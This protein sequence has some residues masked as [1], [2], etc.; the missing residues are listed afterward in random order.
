[1]KYVVID[2]ETGG[3]DATQH[4]L[5]SVGMIK[6]TASF[7]ELDSLY[8]RIRHATLN[9]TPGSLEHNG[10]D[11]TTA[12][13]WTPPD[14]ARKQILEFLDAPAD[15]ATSNTYKPTYVGT[16]T[17][18][19]F[20]MSFLKVFLGE[21]TFDNLFFTRVEEITSSFR[22]LQ[23][24][25]VIT[26]PNGYKLWH[27]MEAL[28]IEIDP[29]KAYTAVEN[30]GFALQAAREMHMRKKILQDSLVSYV[31]KHGGDLYK[32]IEAYKVPDRKAQ[33]KKLRGA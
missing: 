33:M 6:C 7:Q 30:A 18:V 19:L 12:S 13:S 15:I 29:D 5:L 2:C 23:Q 4:S 32:I 3:F 20:D 17:N 21:Q 27:I 26:A 14:I 10:L 25:A 8:V 16:G 1:M 28:G 22:D 31:K 24:T 9:V 11:I